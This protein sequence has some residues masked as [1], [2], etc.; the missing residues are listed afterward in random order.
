[1]VGVGGIGGCASGILAEAGYSVHAVTT[2]T[3]LLEALKQNGCEVK[4]LREPLN[5]SLNVSQTPPVDSLYDY[6]L[7]ATR[8]M[9][10]EEAA[11][12]AKQHLKPDGRMVVFQNGL[13][14]S[15]VASIVGEEK[16]IGG[17]VAWG[18]SK[19]QPGVYEK[20]SSG[21]FSLGTIDGS[22]DPRLTTLS[23]IL[24][25]IGP[26]KI[27]TNL[28]GAR[29]SKLALNSAISSLGTIGGDR[30]GTL[31]RVRRYRRLAL[32]IFTEAVA[33]AKAANISVEK[34]SGTIDLNWGALTEK[35]L[36]LTLGSASL[37]AKHAL[38]L[39][40]GLRYRKLRSSMLS[41]IERG[42]KPDIDFLNGEIV[43][44]GKTHGIN[45]PI[46]AA[47]V[48]KVW[49]LAEGTAKP[50]KTHLDELASLAIQQTDNP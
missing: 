17:I 28:L 11:Q 3:E 10:V 24:E 12:H 40:V 47:I 9:Q 45:T 48:D 41:A 38:L 46:N 37:T 5:I 36:K 34:I 13:C 32:H 35:E 22:T 19:C 1:M 42:R 2:N 14:E 27:T 30:L 29:W 8:P 4:G 43:S 26:T 20:T 25:C 7:L 31:V 44:H 18:A 21:G 49:K 23:T 15:R 39:G 33:V 50:G 16:V 6:I